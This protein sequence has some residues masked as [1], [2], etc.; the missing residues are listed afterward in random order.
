MNSRWFGDRP[1]RGHPTTGGNPKIPT[2]VSDEVGAAQ[3]PPSK[4]KKLPVGAAR[5]SAMT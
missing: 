5:P 2:V 4:F 1:A 3:F